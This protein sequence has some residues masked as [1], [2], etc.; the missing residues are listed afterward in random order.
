SPKQLG[1]VLFEK[2]KIHETLNFTGKLARTTLG[3][4]TDA[5]VL[6]KFSEHPI[7]ALIQEYREL[8]KLLST[9]ILV[10]PSL[11]K[12]STGRLHT[13]FNQIGTATGRLSSSEPNLQNIPIRTSWGKKVRAAFSASKPQH[14]ILSADYSQI[15]LRVLAHLSQDPNLVS[16]FHAQVD[17]H[18]KTAAEILGKALSEVTD[19]ERGRAKAINFGIMYGMG[20]Q[21][22]SKEQKIS[23]NEAKTFIEKYFLNFFHV[24]EYLDSQRHSA[25]KTGQASTFFGRIRP[26][27]EIQSSDQN[28]ARLAENMAINS[29]VQG[30][31]ADI[32]KFGMIQVH[33]ALRNENLQTKIVLQVHD[34]LVLDGPLE[35]LDSVT[36]LVRH[37]ME[38]AVE[39]LIPLTVD[40]KHGKN[41]LE[42][43]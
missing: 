19:E 27:P 4:K 14:I 34:E 38:H 32:M 39:F 8:S 25:H 3:Y 43:K 37:A 9:Y 40:V 2:L 24:K 10:L 17:I 13:H 29:P 31:A 22:L 35:E 18:R 11:V 1:E 26:L 16:A 42:A 12:K 28:M 36:K 6:E 5:E 20:A 30:T 23:F 33:R 7:V 21:R 41:W 15:E